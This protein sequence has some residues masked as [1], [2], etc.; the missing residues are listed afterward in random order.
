VPPSRVAQEAA[1]GRIVV[2]RVVLG[3]QHPRRR[4]RQRDL[5]ERLQT[6]SGQL[7]R[8]RRI[9][10]LGGWGET[11][12]KFFGKGGIWDQIFAQTR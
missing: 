4:Q 11:D 9:G 3:H 10:D 6:R 2:P 1:R 5:G 12:R 7:K 8:L